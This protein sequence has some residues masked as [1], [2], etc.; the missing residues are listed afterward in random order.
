MSDEELARQINE[1]RRQRQA[2]ELPAGP[3]S[4]RHRH[5]NSEP[6]VLI[7]DVPMT[8]EVARVV[9]ANRLFQ[10]LLYGV[11][12]GVLVVVTILLAVAGGTATLIA[13][14]VGLIAATLLV[15]AWSNWSRAGD[16]LAERKILRASGTLGLSDRTTSAELS[17]RRVCKLIV[18]D[19]QLS[20]ATEAADLV[21]SRI[22][23]AV[24]KKST[25]ALT[26]VLTATAG[27]TI[28]FRGTVEY[29]GHSAL[30]LGIRAAGGVLVW[31]HPGLTAE[32]PTRPEPPHSADELDDRPA[33]VRVAAYVAAG[34]LNL[35]IMFVLALFWGLQGPGWSA[36]PPD[37]FASV[38]QLTLT[39]VGA[40]LAFGV[41][42]YLLRIGRRD[43][44]LGAVF[45][46]PWIAIGALGFYYSLSGSRD[47][48]DL[49][50]S[51]SLLLFAAFP[52]AG[53]IVGVRRRTRPSQ[54]Q[55]ETG[56]GSNDPI[57][58]QGRH[59]RT[60]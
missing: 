42:W 50:I 3:A 4:M 6:P 2:G 33:A 49:F 9:R 38:V 39:L 35:P 31:E 56:M 41:A 28:A 44:W 10:R 54:D 30:V 45:A 17:S 43:W 29:T 57:T 53:S 18:G 58:S 11:P 34:C 14:P 37:V 15:L 47:S 46:W 25:S 60:S 55:L 21:R 51:A 36:S 5:R 48:S 40:S 20:I 19:Q 7:S 12:G 27:D 23:V 16:D 59:E 13:F 32:G 24:G 1:R 22:D 52:L 26:A 8:P